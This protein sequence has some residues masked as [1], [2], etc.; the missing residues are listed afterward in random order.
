LNVVRVFA[1][2]IVTL[3]ALLSLMIATFPFHM[4]SV[5]AAIMTEFEGEITAAGSFQR[6]KWPYDVKIENH[7]E[8]QHSDYTKVYEGIEAAG[9]LNGNYHYFTRNLIPSADGQYTIEVDSDKTDLPETDIGG[10]PNDTHMLLYDGTFDPANP[11]ANLLYG[12]EDDAR[13]NSGHRESRMRQ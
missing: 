7:E 12:N 8:L 5:Y 4:L 6:P 2:K 3:A 9:L 10:D 13:L 11:L 1:K